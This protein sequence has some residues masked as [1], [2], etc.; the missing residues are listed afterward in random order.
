MLVG[1]TTFGIVMAAGPC[2]SVGTPVVVEGGGSF[3]ARAWGVGAVSGGVVEVA[4]IVAFGGGSVVVTD[5]SGANPAPELSTAVG[6]TFG[7]GWLTTARFI[8]RF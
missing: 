7:D 3:V 6:E 4:T 8:F 2:A 5:D 1:T